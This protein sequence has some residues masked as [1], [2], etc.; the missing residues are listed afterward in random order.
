MVIDPSSVLS[1]PSTAASAAADAA[2]PSADADDPSPE[3][4]T[5][6][7]RQLGKRTR[8]WS[9]QR[10]ALPLVSDVARH[11]SSAAPP[12]C[13]APLCL[14]L[15]ASSAVEWAAVQER[16]EGLIDALT[17]HLDDFRPLLLPQRST[18]PSLPSQTATSDLCR[19]HD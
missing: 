5:N 4:V 17:S 9:A 15:C 16:G 13:A 10:A 11:Q 12:H 6:A 3:A 18:P 7:L 1:P 14:W 2:S 19:M 8:E